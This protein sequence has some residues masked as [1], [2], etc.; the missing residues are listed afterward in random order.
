M[1]ARNRTDSCNPTPSPHQVNNSYWLGVPAL[2]V[3]SWPQICLDGVGAQAGQG[4]TR[5]RYLLVR[6]DLELFFGLSLGLGTPR[7]PTGTVTVQSPPPP[8]LAV[9]RAPLG[10]SLLG[11]EALVTVTAPPRPAAKG[12]GDP[13]EPKAALLQGMRGCFQAV[14]SRRRV[15]QA[16]PSPTP[17]CAP[18]GSPPEGPGP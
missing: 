1:A 10:E 5:Q 4:H 12:R 14:G 8:A 15:R 7:G 3:P 18:E 13:G 16:C 2:G 17:V 9:P 6:R 11:H